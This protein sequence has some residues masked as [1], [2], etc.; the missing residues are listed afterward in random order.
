MKLDREFDTICAISTPLGPG[1]I[2]II[3]LSGP[4]SLEILKAIFQPANKNCLYHSHRLYYGFIVDKKGNEVIDEALCVYMKAPKTYTREDVVEIQ[5][6]SGPAVLS[7][8]LQICLDKGARLAEPGEFTKRAFLNGR[9]SLSQAEAVLD[10]V[11]AQ[12][13]GLSKLAAHGL[14]G[15][16]SNE[17]LKV[18]E[19]L[20]FCISALEV[21]IDYPE[22]DEEIIHSEN[23]RKRL[24]EEVIERLKRLIDAFEKSK[25][26]RFG[27]KVLLVGKPNAGKSSLLNALSCEERA[28]VTEI[29]G[30]TRDVLEKQIDIEGIPIILIDTAGIRD[31]PNLIEK[32]GIEKIKDFAREATLFLWI[33][34]V[35]TGF[36][37]EDEAVLRFIAKHKNVKKIIVFNK[38][39]KVNDFKER[40]TA[41]FHRIKELLNEQELPFVFISAKKHKGLDKLSNII[42]QVLVGERA[43]QEIKV[44][45]NLRQKQILEQTLSF[46]SEA[47]NGLLNSIS[48]E[49]IAFDLRQALNLLGEITGETATEEILDKIFSNFCLGK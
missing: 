39:D 12:G 48:P 10:I 15:A 28:I 4:K 32:I 33:I 42:L 34:D 37:T 9:I 3:R 2:G 13:Q 49:L 8:I 19:E 29:P 41:I 14:T 1:G 21:A 38:I 16:L 45:P 22:D 36:E 27:A 5:C 35:E 23:I 24:S 30:T 20:L 17:I 40:A 44:A 7:H 11:T 18:K 47:Y 25:I 43:P 31:A 26:Q 6:H 46:V